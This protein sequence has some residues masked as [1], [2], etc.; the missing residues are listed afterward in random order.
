MKILAIALFMMASI[1]VN[2][3]AQT[4]AILLPADEAEGFELGMVY[5]MTSVER[6]MQQQA[7]PAMLP[8][9]AVGMFPEQERAGKSIV[10]VNP[11]VDA[12]TPI[13]D[14]Q[15][16]GAPVNNSSDGSDEGELVAVERNPEFDMATLQRS[17]IYPPAATQQKIEGTVV[18]GA[19]VGAEGAVERVRILRSDNELLNAAAATAVA[20]TPFT[21]GIMGGETG[22]L[23]VRIPVT[24]KLD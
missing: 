14:V 6:W 11:Q 13:W 12:P 4:H 17:I 22:R 2:V 15:L 21:P 23:W 19:L 24:F 10:M 18:V 20:M 3:V 16:S 7:P 5:P 8:L 9:E 1:T